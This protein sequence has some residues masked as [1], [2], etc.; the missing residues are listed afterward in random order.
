MQPGDVEDTWADSSA[1]A[2]AIGYGPSTPVEEG[3]ARFVAWYKS[4]YKV[5]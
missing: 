5:N 4:Y 2:D 1:L 3:L